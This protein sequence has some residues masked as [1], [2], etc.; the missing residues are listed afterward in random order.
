M[1][2]DVEPSPVKR[3]RRVVSVPRRS[4]RFKGSYCPG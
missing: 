2:V 3:K 1:D 4:G